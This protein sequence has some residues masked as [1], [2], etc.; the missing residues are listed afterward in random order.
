MKKS[1]L[2]AACLALFA[3]SFS[4]QSTIKTVHASPDSYDLGERKVRVPAPDNFTDT[5]VLYPRIAGR[6]VASESPLN[7]VLAVHVTDEIL[8]QIKNGEEPDLPFYTKVSVLKQFKAVDVESADF[9]SLVADVEKQSPG[10]LQSI[11][12]SGEKTSNEGLNKHW[13]GDVG[14]KIGETRILG[15]FD[16]QLQSYSTMFI[17]NLEM[18]NR[19]MTVLGSMSLVHVNKRV[20]FLYIFRLPTSASDQDVVANVAK[21]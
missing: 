20:L 21:S 8:P 10:A 19:K 17:V 6:L 1:P 5:M 18:F 13:G 12:K 14:L 15:H 9:Q 11:A 2:L 3:I 16:K 7:E 4:A